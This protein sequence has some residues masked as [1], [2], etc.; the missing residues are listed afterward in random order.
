MAARILKLEAELMNHKRV[1]EV[2]TKGETDESKIKSQMASKSFDTSDD[3][4]DHDDNVV[5]AETIFDYDMDGDNVKVSMDMVVD[6]NCFVPV[7]TREDE[8]RVPSLSAITIIDT[9]YKESTSY[10]TIIAMGT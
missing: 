4:N 5:G 7:P 9:E 1:P 8:K 3:A 6:G 2:A 10:T